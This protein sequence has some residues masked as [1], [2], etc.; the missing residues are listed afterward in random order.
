MTIEN[1]EDYERFSISLPKDLFEEFEYYRKSNNITRSEA[2]RR[3]MRMYLKN[4]SKLKETEKS[5][6]N[7][8]VVGVICLLLE[9]Y[10]IGDKHD[11][12]NISLKEHSEAH[13][14]DS[15][16]E[17]LDKNYYYYQDTDLIKLNHIEHN[18]HDIVTNQLHIHSEHDRC[19][20]IIPVKGP[21]NRIRE[22]YSKI[23]SLKSILSHDIFIEQ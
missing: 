13:L 14:H 10:Y 15:L 5:M 21:S 20:I 18:Y 1:K 2:I 4:I 6:E 3:G 7:K 12:S 16:D 8:P 17:V 9:H 11:H 19:L 23:I 22:F